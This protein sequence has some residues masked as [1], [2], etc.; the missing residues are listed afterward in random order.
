MTPKT[1]DLTLTMELIRPELEKLG[2]Q[3]R[4]Y[5]GQTL[6][7]EYLPSGKVGAAPVFYLGKLGADIGDERQWTKFSCPI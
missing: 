1:I 3:F 5:Q 4:E 6:F 2:I 7:Y